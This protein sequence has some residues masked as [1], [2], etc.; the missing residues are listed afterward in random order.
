MTDKDDK[1]EE[2]TEF[3][4][5]LKDYLKE[6]PANGYLNEVGV[7]LQDYISAKI[8]FLDNKNSNNPLYE[9]FITCLFFVVAERYKESWT[10]IM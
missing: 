3:N 9:N 8:M 1:E 4:L 7:L 5:M 2:V 6:D 10:W